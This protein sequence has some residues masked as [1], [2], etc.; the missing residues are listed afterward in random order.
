MLVC[1][2]EI[3]QLTT[4][5]NQEHRSQYDA[6]IIG[7]GPGGEGAA[8]KLAGAGLSV[9]VIEEHH[10]IGGGCLHWGTIPSK[11]LRHEIQLIRDYRNHPLFLKSA[12]N[13]EVDYPSLLAAADQIAAKQV[14]MKYQDFTEHRIHVIHGRARF[15]DQNKIEV[16]DT[17][18]GS[19]EYQADKFI[20]ATGSRPYHP[21]DID[22]THP[23]ILD[24]DKVLQLGF[25]PKSII[26]YG[27]GVIG[28]EY[29]SIFSNLG[30][31]VT[32]VNMHDRLMGYMDDEISDALSYTLRK[33]G[34][35]IQHNETYQSVEIDDESVI[36]H[37]ESGKQIRADALLWANGR[38]G[39]TDDMGLNS[40]G[41]N[42]NHRGQIEVG[43]NLQTSI[44]N[45]YAVGD[46]IGSPGLASASYD[47]GRFVASCIA[48]G[49][50]S[51]KLVQDIPIGIY[52]TP[53]ISSV[54]RTEKELTEKQIPYEIGRAHFEHIA[55]AQ[56][57]GHTTGMLKLLFHRE[58]L[59][60]LGIHCFGEQ[61]SEIIHIGQAIMAQP[62]PGNSLNYFLD[63]TFNYPTMAE[64]YRVAAIDGLQRLT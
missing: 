15:I 30:I 16:I 29:A 8:I 63:N 53:E 55:R 13:L 40:L 3:T 7:S 49:T 42:I 45:I 22:F 52:T 2:H 34:C 33:R 60:I 17:Q 5:M 59:E 38:T 10:E 36:L 46:V 32:L 64:A 19:K 48:D 43:K 1:V 31:R 37:C 18:G 6:I 25:S 14:S 4:E 62:T 27:A 47:Q 41:V 57:T 58:T 23:R 21:E 9:A 28:S 12:R 20:V 24:S 51:W 61:A 56:I 54:G 39:N 44:E 11:T 26:I 50:C 35:D